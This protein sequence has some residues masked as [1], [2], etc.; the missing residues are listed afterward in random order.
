MPAAQ[1]QFLELVQQL[2]GQQQLGP[3]LLLDRQRP[4]HRPRRR[5]GHRRHDP[6]LAQRG[7][8]LDRHLR[9]HLQPIVDD[10]LQPVAIQ[11][12]LVVA[13]H[14]L[15]D[16]DRVTRRLRLDEPLLLLGV[17]MRRIRMTERPD[18]RA[19]AEEYGFP[20]H[21]IGG[22]VYWDETV[23]W[24]FTLREIEDDLETPTG[25]LEQ[26]CLAFVGEALKREPIL[27]KLDIPDAYWSFLRTAGA[28]ATAISTAL[29]PRLRR[30]GAGEAA[31][32]QRRHA[33]L[34]LRGRGLPVDLARGPDGGGPAA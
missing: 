21:T 4:R 28:G 23:A 27:R 25:E 8:P 32:I 17:L 31:R 15:V 24:S 6:A 20:F 30:L 34:A 10:R 9:R 13:E 3:A 26:M 1:L 29:R 2:L 12:E 19:K 33:D 7:Q 18:W 11:F 22:E 5:R 14:L 16:L